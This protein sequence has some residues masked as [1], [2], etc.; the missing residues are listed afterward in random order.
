MLD[1]IMKI[2]LPGTVMRTPIPN[3]PTMPQVA[4][5][6][7]ATVD[8]PEWGSVVQCEFTGGM[9]RALLAAGYLAPGPWKLLALAGMLPSPSHSGIYLSE[10]EI[11]SLNGDGKVVVE[12][13]EDFLRLGAKS[14]Y[15]SC[16][17]EEGYGLPSAACEA[18]N[19][20]GEKYDYDLV[21]N[22]CHKFVCGCMR[23]EF[24]GEY[25]MSENYSEE[26]FFWLDD[27]VE[28]MKAAKIREHHGFIESVA[29]DLSQPIKE[30]ERLD[31]QLNPDHFDPSN[32]FNW[33][34]WER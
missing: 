27:V 19:R 29:K 10:T 9:H 6:D 26:R 25:K 4:V 23:E 7:R 30:I 31:E 16:F 33:R 12:T 18:E 3:Q 13:P 22:N 21:Y 5:A 32:G 17:G 8:E 20:V 28:E 1:D 24:E 15:V 11:V 2:L 34:V 14:I